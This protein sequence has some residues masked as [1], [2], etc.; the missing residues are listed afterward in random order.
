MKET[1]ARQNEVIQLAVTCMM[2][3]ATMLSEEN[4]REKD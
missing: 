1:S 3:E 4:Q 2:L